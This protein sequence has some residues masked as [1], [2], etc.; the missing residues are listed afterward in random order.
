MKSEYYMPN[1]FIIPKFN[2][3]VEETSYKKT[4]GLLLDKY[5]TA[6][7]NSQNTS[8]SVAKP[9]TSK[10]MTQPY[11]PSNPNVTRLKNKT[12]NSSKRYKLGEEISY[13]SKQSSLLRTPYTKGSEFINAEF[14]EIKTAKILTYDKLDQNK[15]VKTERVGE[16]M[17]GLI[18]PVYI[19]HSIP[20]KLLNHKD[21]QPLG[22][23]V[24]SLD[25]TYLNHLELSYRDFSEIIEFNKKAFEI[26]KV[27]DEIKER[28]LFEDKSSTKFLIVPIVA[29]QIVN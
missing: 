13:N 19:G 2:I 17:F 3:N 25:I 24:Q 29:G 23:E 8:V 20:M 26:L 14:Y 18:V 11:Q 1:D 6:Y 22:F 16:T 9:P 5:L 27:K 15:L 10:I 12:C 28:T 21:A 7:N 4:V